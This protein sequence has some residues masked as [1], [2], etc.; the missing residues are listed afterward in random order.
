MPIPL[1]SLAFGALFG[2]AGNKSKEDF[3]AVK[4]R[5]KRTEQPERLS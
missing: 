2:S 1:L 5:K 4:G 3:Q